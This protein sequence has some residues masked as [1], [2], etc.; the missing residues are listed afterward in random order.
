MTGHEECRRVCA[1]TCVPS[2]SLRHRSQI[3]TH[4]SLSRCRQQSVHAVIFRT[5][6]GA[7]VERHVALA[8]LTAFELPPPPALLPMWA[9]M[10]SSQISPLLG[11]H[12]T[13]RSVLRSVPPTVVPLEVKKMYADQIKGGKP[14]AFC[15]LVGYDRVLMWLTVFK[16]T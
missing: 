13:L 14:S 12:G 16:N 2:E 11:P 9:L 5:L 3:H 15:D 4:L 8:R 7:L 10:L 6:T 1:A